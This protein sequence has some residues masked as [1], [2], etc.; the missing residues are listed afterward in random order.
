MA[1]RHLTPAQWNSLS[2]DDRLDLLAY[3]HRRDEYRA[4][5]ISE[6]QSK[7]TGGDVSILAQLMILLND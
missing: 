5:L 3:E 6:A 1:R 2:R 7:I 4:I